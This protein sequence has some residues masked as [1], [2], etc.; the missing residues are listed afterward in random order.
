MK[1]ILL[2]IQYDGSKYSG[3]QRQTN[4]VTIQGTI[5]EA[6]EKLCGK[7]IETIGCS[8][9][10]SGVHAR[11]YI[12]NFHIESKMPPD[13]YQPALNGILPEDIVVLNSKEVNEDFHARYSSKGKKYSYYILNRNYPCAINRKYVYH[14]KNPLSIDLMKECS[15][16][17]IGT[18]DFS[19][20]KNSGSSII[21]NI[22]TINSI[23]ITKKE[24]LL[25]ISIEGN[26]FLYNMVR[27]IVG[28]FIEVGIGKMKPNYI[29]TIL[30]SKDRNLAGITIPA[31]G[32]FLEKVFY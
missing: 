6:I 24:D 23:D 22:R 8:R 7:Y 29:N 15:E 12:L 10:D 14:Y 2:K 3:W 17:L 28:T 9:T 16:Y 19:A 13:K 31:K 21:N 20:F 32:L 25:E 30:E 5:E 1:N 18:H 26:G 27:I 11:E 4:A